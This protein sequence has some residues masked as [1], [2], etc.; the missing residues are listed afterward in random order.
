M[1]RVAEA[2]KLIRK[3]A[4]T[5]EYQLLYNNAK[6]LGFSVFRNNRDFSTVQSQFLSS[7]NLHATICMD[8]YLNEVTDIVLEDEIYED[9][10]LYYKQKT[11]DKEK[12]QN[13]PNEYKKSSM[14]GPIQRV[15]R[16]KSQWQFRRRKK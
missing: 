13:M 6:E 4:R 16:V 11:K 5:H 15:S 10:Y 8:I 9:A 3:L 14:S 2:P 1:I 7:L 12:T